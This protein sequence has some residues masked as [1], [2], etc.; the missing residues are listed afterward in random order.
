MDQ[1]FRGGDPTLLHTTHGCRQQQIGIFS[2][3]DENRAGHTFP[4]VPQRDVQYHGPQEQALDGGVVVMAI[5]SIVAERSAV[6]CHVLPLVVG[7][8]TERLIDFTQMLFELFDRAEAL[9]EP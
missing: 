2:T 9:I 6:F 8:H 3:Q 1:T 4:D 5:P 7:E